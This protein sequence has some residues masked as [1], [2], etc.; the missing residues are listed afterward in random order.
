MMR[1]GVLGKRIGVCTFVPIEWTKEFVLFITEMMHLTL[2]PYHQ[3]PLLSFNEAVLSRYA[4]VSLTVESD[5][6]Y[7]S[8]SFLS[9]PSSIYDIIYCMI[10]II[11]GDGTIMSH[12]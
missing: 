11:I 12:T 10:V 6:L 2:L 5:I 7:F 3:F 4:L 1:F 8:F 9:S